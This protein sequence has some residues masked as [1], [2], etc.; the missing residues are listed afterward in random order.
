MPVYKNKNSTKDG[1]AWQFRTYYHSIEG[2]KLQKKSVKY[3]TTKEAEQAEREF[4]NNIDNFKEIQNEDLTLEKLNIDFMEYR[5]GEVKETTYD[6]YKDKIR[7]LEVLK[8]LK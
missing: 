2:T 7:Y 3:F 5:K 4:L 8:I 1:R 6:I